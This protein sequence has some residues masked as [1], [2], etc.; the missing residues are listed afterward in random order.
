VKPLDGVTVTVEDPLLPWA[1]VTF[2]AASENDALPLAVDATV[3]DSVAEEAE[4]AVLLDG[5]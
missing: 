5:V 4:F 2:V 1:T 3:I